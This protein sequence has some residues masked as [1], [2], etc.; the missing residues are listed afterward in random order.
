MALLVK[1]AD[2]GSN[3]APERVAQL[4]AATRE[5]LERKYTHALAQLNVPRTTIDALHR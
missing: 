1:T 2:L 4:D 3:L 5:R